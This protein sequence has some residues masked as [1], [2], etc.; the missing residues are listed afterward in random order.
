MG[1]SGLLVAGI[2]GAAMGSLSSALNSMSN[3][4]VADF[5]HSFF[6]TVPSDD[7]MLRWPG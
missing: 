4:T 7:A 1:I 3:S 5:I 2:L 6:R